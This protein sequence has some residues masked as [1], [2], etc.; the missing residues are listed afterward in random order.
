MCE[1]CWLRQKGKAK[2]SKWR[3]LCHLCVYRHWMQFHSTVEKEKEFEG[4]FNFLQEIP[5]SPLCTS[6]PRPSY[7]QLSKLPSIK[8]VVTSL[9][10]PT[11][12][13]VV[14]FSVGLRFLENR[15]VF[16]NFFQVGFM[17]LKN[18]GNPLRVVEKFMES[19]LSS[20]MRLRL[21]ENFS[22][23]LC[24]RENILIIIIVF[25]AI[26]FP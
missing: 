19:A 1:D 20:W 6:Q 2:E 3:W 4:F 5:H 9:L 22:V 7:R 8:T 13:L 26:S 11:K 14:T 12:K 24:L 18:L 10:H 15:F 17:L 25:H 16:L 23:W 21:F